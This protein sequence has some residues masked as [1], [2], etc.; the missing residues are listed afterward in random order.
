MDNSINIIAEIGWN[1]MGDIE[2]AKKMIVEAKK[3]GANI[4]KFQFWSPK[5][6]KPGPWDNDGRREIYNKAALDFEKINLLNNFCKDNDIGSLYSVFTL[7]DAKEILK[8]DNRW[9]KI[10]S[11]EV[12]N[13]D[14]ITFCGSNF[15]TI[16]LSTGACAKYEL[17]KSIEILKSVKANFIIMHCVS[18]YPCEDKNLNLPRMEWLK[19]FGFPIGL[20]DHTSSV[21][22]GCAAVAMGAI[23]I[24]KHFT[25][26][27]DL[28]GR[29]NKFALT[30]EKFKS[31]T[32]NINSISNMLISHGLNSQASEQDIIDNYRGRWGS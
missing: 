2:L 13:L 6:L 15:E 4:A 30:P 8:I 10:P 26:D 17:E 16:F 22:S 19:N 25:T 7:S 24:E 14:L 29:D 28:P 1:F 18:S 27:N 20:S 12:A 11:H 32:D 9:I 23:A 3:S 5:K 31:M 21:V